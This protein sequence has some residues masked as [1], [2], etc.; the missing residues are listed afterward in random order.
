M[1]DKFAIIGSG[2]SFIATCTVRPYLE[3]EHGCSQEYP[4]FLLVKGH[5]YFLRCFDGSDPS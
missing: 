1:L 2:L 4:Y 5:L 3:S